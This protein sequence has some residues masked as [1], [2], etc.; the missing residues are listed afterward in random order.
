M[1]VSGRRLDGH[2]VRRGRRQVE[3]FEPGSGC[4]PGRKQWVL[5]VGKCFAVVEGWRARRRLGREVAVAWWYNGEV[6]VR[7][8]EAWWHSRGRCVLLRLSTSDR[9]MR[10]D[11]TARG[12]VIWARRKRRRVPRD[13][14]DI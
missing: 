3:V 12:R 8:R 11:E 2:E 9:G 14:W 1:P 6:V 4:L 10:V 5:C 7:V 13:A